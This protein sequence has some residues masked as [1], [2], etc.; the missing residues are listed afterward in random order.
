MCSHCAVPMGWEAKPGWAG[1][2]GL[3]AELRWTGRQA[4][5]QE[6]RKAGRIHERAPHLPGQHIDGC[7]GCGSHN[8]RGASCELSINIKSPQPALA[9][10]PGGRKC[11]DQLRCTACTAVALAY[12]NCDSGCRRSCSY[13]SRGAG[14]CRSCSCSCSCSSSA[15]TPARSACSPRS[16]CGSPPAVRCKSPMAQVSQ[17]WLSRSWQRRS[18]AGSFVWQ[19]ERGATGSAGSSTKLTELHASALLILLRGT[20]KAGFGAGCGGGG[21]QEWACKLLV[22]C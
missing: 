12:D 20:E 10:S 16:S 13:Y 2:T 3:V 19:N 22:W 18:W 9:P 5:Y 11:A 6:G 7:A 8:T 21:G 1:C 15:F 4:K 14:C 17:N